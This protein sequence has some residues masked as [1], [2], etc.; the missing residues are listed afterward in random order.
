MIPLAVD[1]G[2]LNRPKGARPMVRAPL[3]L[4]PETIEEAERRARQRGITAA[5]ILREILE[6]DLKP[7]P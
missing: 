3:R 5:E 2:Y 1:G 4:L 7:R 6:R